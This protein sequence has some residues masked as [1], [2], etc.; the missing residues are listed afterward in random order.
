MKRVYTYIRIVIFLV[1]AAQNTYCEEH[2]AES[3]PRACNGSPALC[4]R[5]FDNVTFPGSHNSM[6]NRDDDWSLPNHTHGIEAQMAF[7]L[8]AINLD[9]YMF[10]GEPYSCHTHCEIGRRKLSEMLAA[11]KDFMEKNPDEVFTLWLQDMAGA[12]NLAGTFEASG[13]LQYALRQ[14]LGDPWPTLGEMIDSGKRIVIIGSGGPDWYL[15]ENDFMWSSPWDFRKISEFK[16]GAP[17]G[18]PLYLLQHFILNPYPMEIYA[19]KANNKKILM[20]RAIQCWRE[21]GR[22]PNTIV[23]DF[24]DLGDLIQA[25]NELNAFSSVMDLKQN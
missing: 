5:A 15:S 14:K 21:T 10:D 20:K 4:D 13:I 3:A 2:G 19:K 6:S 16:C 9:V 18:R 25:V 23:V 17:D 11:I 7:G 12:D 24:Y 22:R 1:A 8:R